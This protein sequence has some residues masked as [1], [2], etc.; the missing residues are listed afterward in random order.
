VEVLL[1]IF[2]GDDFVGRSQAENVVYD[3][4]RAVNRPKLCFSEYPED[5]K[6][7]KLQDPQDSSIDDNFR[8][9]IAYV[10]SHFP[11]DVQGVGI[12]EANMPSFFHVLR[13]LAKRSR[14]CRVS[15]KY[16]AL[17]LISL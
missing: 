6:S 10:I 9:F 7:L 2:I 14:D 11:K 5:G 12:Y 1:P 3:L 15:R 13:W 8:V 16:P 4:F 17:I